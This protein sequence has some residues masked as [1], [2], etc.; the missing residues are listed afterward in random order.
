M[1]EKADSE[2]HSLSTDEKIA[3]ISKTTRKKRSMPY[4]AQA[5]DICTKKHAK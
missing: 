5:C 1:G 3:S 2:L 4:A